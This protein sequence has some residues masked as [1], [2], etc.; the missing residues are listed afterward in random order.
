[1]TY[2][3]EQLYQLLPTI[4]RLRDEQR[5]QPLRA[6][7]DVIAQQA[8]LLEADIARLYENWFIETCEEW[9]VPYIGDLLGVRGLRSFG[10]GSF[11]QRAHVAHTLGNRRRKGTAS[12]LEQLARDTT[13]WPA[14]VVE[15]FQLLNTT[16]FANHI[17]LHNL[18]T[19]D[20]RQVAALELLDGPFDSIAHTVDVRHMDRGGTRHN[21]MNIGICLWRLQAYPIDRAPA[22]AHGDGCYSFS[23][24]G[25]DAPLFTHPLT[26]TDPAQHAGEINVPAPIRRLA[27]AASLQS[28]EEQ[29]YGRGLS[30]QL[31]KNGMEVP[32]NNVV[33]CDLSG[34]QHRPAADHVA[35][36][37]VCGR[38]T[39]PAGEAAANLHVAYHYGFSSALGGGCYS[40]LLPIPAGPVVRYSI[41]KHL[42]LNSVKAAL[43]RWIAQGSGNAI[44]EIEDSETYT[45][46]LT[47]NIPAGVR[48]EIRAAPQQRPML[49]LIRSLAITGAVP[50]ESWQPGGEL[51]FNGLLISGERLEI[52]PGDLS[53]LQLHHCT[54]VP[55]WSLAIDGAA[56]SPQEPSLI[57][58][59]ENRRLNIVLTR[60]ITGRLVLPG[61][62][63]ATLTDC[64]VDGLQGDALLATRLTVRESTVLGRTSAAVIELASNSIFREPVLAERKQ[65]GC[66]RF[67]YLAASSIVPRRYRCVTDSASGAMRPIFTSVNY[68][69][70]GY[71]QLHVA[72]PLEIGN[73]AD[74]QAE[75]GVFHHLQ[76]PQRAAN[77]LRS[78][79]EYL[80]AGLQAGL[81]Y[82]T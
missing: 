3:T 75:M 20:L 63:H 78:L 55:G 11:S 34:W 47:V 69:Q 7:I 53:S 28:A 49:R 35:V 81:S 60:T 6:L 73:G 76:Q 54:L 30:I 44:L 22:F 18:Q 10:E 8:A 1:M 27:L 51:L 21:I 41:A 50:S 24:L 52:H 68:G 48:L 13:G 70:P 72:C 4:Y 16:Q 46:E 5:G 82:V 74:D 9:A 79:P 31:W 80:R 19:P 58:L 66:V 23:Q 45:E 42:P 65:E 15:C 17:R 36:D 14:R 57:V 56:V 25:Q 29:Y 64:L 37:P 38:I 62:E 61:I 40:R 43:N 71:G 2:T 59:A 32:R 77:L 33:A 12:M 39:L 67:C 26:E